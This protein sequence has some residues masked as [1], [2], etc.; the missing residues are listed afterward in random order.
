M[1]LVTKKG[2]K[3]ANRKALQRESSSWSWLCHLAPGQSFNWV[4]FSSNFPYFLQLNVWHSFRG[5]LDIRK[6]FLSLKHLLFQGLEKTGG[7]GRK[8]NC[9]CF[10][11]KVILVQDN[12]DSELLAQVK[13]A[14]I[15]NVGEVTFFLMSLPGKKKKDACANGVALETENPL[16]P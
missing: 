4:H 11:P 14:K 5:R 9:F 16:V 8:V 3:E 15:P 10:L 7:G 12:W 6:S 1:A 13:D 2:Q